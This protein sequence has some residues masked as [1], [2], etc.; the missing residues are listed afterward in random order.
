MDSS[1]AVACI[2]STTATPNPIAVFAP[3]RPDRIPWLVTLDGARSGTI[4]KTDRSRSRKNKLWRPWTSPRH[5]L[6]NQKLIA[7]DLRTP[8]EIVSWLGVVQSQDYAGAKWALALRAPGLRDAD[9]ERACDDGVILRTHILRP[10]WHFVAPE[11]LRWM[12]QLAGP[13]LKT[14]NSHYCR[15]SGLDAKTLAKSRRIIEG[16]LGIATT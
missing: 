13:R 5:R 12:Q 10:T 11:D 3:S 1:S 2:K 6:R 14:A 9:I 7:S 16:A 4:A 8:L 15:K